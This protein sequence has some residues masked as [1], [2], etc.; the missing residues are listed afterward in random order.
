MSFVL[1]GTDGCHLCDDAV[2]VIATAAAGLA[3][4][5]YS[6]D[7]IDVDGGVDQYGLRIPVLRDEISGIELDWPFTAETVR[8]LFENSGQDTVND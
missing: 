5:V 6:E 7:I 8:T 3:V 2:V 1:Y 4:T